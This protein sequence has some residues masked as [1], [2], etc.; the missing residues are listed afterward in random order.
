M[1]DK[2]VKT[3][4][5]IDPRLLEL[6]EEIKDDMAALQAKIAP[7]MRE[8]LQ[9]VVVNTETGEEPDDMSEDIKAEI[10]A[11][12]D[13]IAGI[14]GMAYATAWSYTHII[15]NPIEAIML[16]NS[17][18]TFTHKGIEEATAYN[19]VVNQARH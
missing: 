1:C 12:Q 14:M 10:N 8:I 5:E 9:M 13:K 7:K 4:S 15:N 6:M 11:T 16:G 17:I 3:A 19:Y 18:I 2:C